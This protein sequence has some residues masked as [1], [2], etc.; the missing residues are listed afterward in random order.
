MII[1]INMNIM[2]IIIYAMLY[3]LIYQSQTEQMYSK[4]KHDAI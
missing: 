3:V 4:Y 2:F 1:N